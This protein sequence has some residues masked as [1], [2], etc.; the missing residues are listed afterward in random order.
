[1]TEVVELD[2]DFL[3]EP[4]RLYALLREEAPVCVAE[5]PDGERLWLVTRYEDVRAALTDPAIGKD[6]DEIMRIAQA[7]GMTDPLGGSLRTHML[8]SDPP[9]HTRLRKLVSKVFTARA[10]ER[11]RPRI[12]EIADE[13]IAAVAAKDEIDLLAEFA[14]P[15]PLTVICELLGVA[16]DDRDDFRQW[17]YAITGTTGNYR[18][19]RAA[20]AKMAAYLTAS[21][22][23]KRARPRA[24]LLSQLVHARDGGDGLSEREL[25]STAFLLLFAG[26][27]TTVN[28]IASGIS[29]LLRHPDQL[30][31]LRADRALLPGAIEEFLRYESPVNITSSRY[32]KKA[33]RIGGV[34]IPADEFI[35]VALASANRDGTRF[36]DPDTVEITRQPKGHVAFGYGVHYCLGAPLARLE[37]EI[38][39]DRLLSAFPHLA[40]AVPADQLVW[41]ESAHIRGLTAL[42]V[43][44]RRAPEREQ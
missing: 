21:V 43:R 17:S 41:R 32:T 44:L 24:D 39:F 15:L 1:M 4:Y 38:A 19:F 9:D 6:S 23:Q 20:A 22:A 37:A 35:V 3:R 34:D 13:L 25:V 40:P 18:N 11:L 2:S 7:G 16:T 10:V 33:T 30:A 31:A 28:L 8:N 42:P 26:H 36:A 27:E 12:I 14:Y 5:L 29:A